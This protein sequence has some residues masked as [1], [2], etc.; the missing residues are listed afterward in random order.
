[1]EGEGSAVRKIGWVVGAVIG[2]L[3]LVGPLLDRVVFPEPEPGPEYIPAVG[4]TFH[5][6]SE[7]FTQRI[8]RR[9]EGLIWSELTLH[10]HAPGP[11]AHVHTTFS[12]RF[13]VERGTV[14]MLVGSELLRLNAGEEFLVEPGV[15]HQPFNETDRDAVVVGPLTPD[16]ALPERFGIFL[17]QAYGFFDA[18]P[19]NGMAPR[20]ILQMSRFSPAYDSWIAGP[21]VALQKT[22]Y[23]A[24]AP[25]ARLLGYRT[26][27][28]EYVPA[29]VAER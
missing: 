28:P 7:G 5:S 29:R 15:P 18:S 26:A 10:P 3:F 17:T 25:I 4:Q 12:E 8:I 11:P 20:A 6:D 23:W 2:I 9:D 19:E 24:V 13:R 14:A 27:Y 22:V 1:M 16:Y 21:P